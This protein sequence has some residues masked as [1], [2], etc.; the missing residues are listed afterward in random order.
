[1]ENQRI[2]NKSDMWFSYY[3]GSDPSK[4]EIFSI[5]SEYLDKLGRLLFF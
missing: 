5:A 3:F 2:R 4:A 1:M